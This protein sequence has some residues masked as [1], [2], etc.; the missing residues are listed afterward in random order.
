MSA[1]DMGKMTE[2]ADKD[3]MSD[4][5]D[6]SG[7]KRGKYAERYA[8]G[9]NVV[10]LEP[11]VYEI[12]HDSESVNEALRPLANLIRKRKASA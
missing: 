3:E 12:F 11:D 7:G 2:M 1:E 6:F 10:I 4:E 5:Y 8:Q 9:A